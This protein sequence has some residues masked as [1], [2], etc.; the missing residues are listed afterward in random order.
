MELELGL[1]MSNYNRVPHKISSFKELDLISYVNNCEAKQDDLSSLSCESSSVNHGDY[2]QEE[3]NYGLCKKKR[4][5]FE[6][7]NSEFCHHQSKTL[8]LLFWDKQPNEDDNIPISFCNSQTQVITKNEGDDIVGWPPIKTYRKRQNYGRNMPMVENGGCCGGSGSL[9]VKVQ[10]EGCFITRKI[11][12]RL[13][14]SCDTLTLS[15]LHMFGKGEDR[16]DDYKLTYQDGEG[17]WLLVADNV[18]WRTLI[19]TI[20]RLKMV[21]K[22]C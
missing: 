4:R 10:M 17:N 3:M 13:Y 15:L 16:M 9:Y 1:S 7:E 19:Q 18:P 22:D 20:R 8:S 21:R 6:A 14:H 5:F 12:L 11:N 2:D